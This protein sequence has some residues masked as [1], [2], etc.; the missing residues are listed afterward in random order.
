MS[1]SL[2]LLYH[3]YQEL[4]LCGQSHMTAYAFTSSL[5]NIFAVADKMEEKGKLCDSY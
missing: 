1:T 5:V 3:Y 4:S 2:L